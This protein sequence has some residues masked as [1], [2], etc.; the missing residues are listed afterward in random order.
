M[1]AATVVTNIVAVLSDAS[2]LFIVA[3]GL[4]LVFGAM[5]LINVA[6]GS[7]YMYGAFLVTTVA[8]VAVGASFWLALVVGTL[9][10]GALG[11]L[12]EVTVMRRIYNKEHLTQLLATFAVFL[13]LADLA[14]RFWGKGIRSVS[15]PSIAAGR[16]TVA[17]ATFPTYDLV[18]IGIALAV[19]AALWLL[20][21]RT[22][23]GWRI[24]AAVE[25]PE[26]LQAGGTNLALLRGGVFVVGA[27]LAGL[28]GAVVSPRI[29]VAPGI[30]EAI[31]VSAFIVAVIGGLGSITGAAI[32]AL[33]IGI[34]DTVGAAVAPTWA[35]SFIFLAMIV[36]LAV[37]PW[38]LLGVAER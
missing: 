18:I 37:R 21:A 2:S 17:G 7:F 16:L 28:A 24:R 8:G 30:G 9:V 10:V 1:S 27:M 14:L 33:L 11:G 13:I 29:S 23:L 38:G 3:S 35:S 4:T 6:H 12:T 20:L 22:V 25:D 31:I 36:V 32:G 15:P 19:G 5:R 34:A 26:S